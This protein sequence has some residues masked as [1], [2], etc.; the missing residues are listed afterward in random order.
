MNSTPGDMRDAPAPSH[1][2]CLLPS[3]AHTPSVTE[4]TPA[5][6]ITF[7]KRG[8][9]RFAGVRLA[10]HQR[11]F[12]TF[13]A[14][15]DELSQRVPLSFGVRS[16]TTPRGLHGLSALEQLQDGGCYLCSDKKP[17]KTPREPGQ[18]QRKS[19]SAGQSRGFEGGHEAPEI[20][21]SWKGPVAPRRLTLV[22]NGNPRCQQTV[23]VSHR[24]T[25]NLKAFLSKASELL[26][27]PVKQVY[28]PSGKKVDS[29]QTLLDGP[30]L[31]VCAGNEAFRHLEMENDGRHRTRTLSGVTARSGRGCWGP[32]AKQSVMHSRARSGSRLQQ[33]S[34]MSERSGPS[35]HP[36]SG[37]QTWA[38]PTLDKHPRDTPGPPGS[39]VAADDVEKKVCMNEDGSL[40]VEMKVRFQILGEDTLRWPQRVGYASVFAPASGEGQVPREADPFCCKQEGH[41][42][43]FLTHGA[44]GLEP[45]DGRYQGAFDMDQQSQ[46][47][48]DIWR[49]PL[50]TSGGAGPTRRRRWGL[51]KLSGC[52]SHWNQTANDKKGHSNNSP[53]SGPRHPRSAQPGSSCP[54]TSE[55]ETDSDTLH[56]ASSTSSLSGAELGAG[57]DRSLEDTASC[58]LGSETQ[59]I[60]K[61]LSDTSASAESHEMSR[62][63]REQHHRGS[64]QARVTVSQGQATQGDRPC[65]STQSPS[66]LSHMHLQTEKYTQGTTYQEVRGEPELRLPLVPG[67]SASQDTQRHTLP[68]PGG[69]PAQQRQKKQ[70]RPAGIVCLSGA[71]VPYQGAQKGHTRQCHC[72]RD[73]QSSLDTVL[74]RQMPEEGE[75]A[76]PGGL[77]PRFS[78][79]SPSAENEV[80]GDLKSPLSSSLD[81][82]DPQATS[83]A[84]ILPTSDSDCASSFCHPNTRSAEPAGDTECPAHSPASIPVHSGEVGY[85]WDKAGTNP[86]PFSAS[87]LLD[88]WPEAEDPRTHQD[89]CG[90]QVAASPVLTGP[91][92]QT[93]APISEAYWG[94]PNFCPTP[95]QEQTCSRKD[96]T[97]SNSPSSDHGQTDGQ[98]EPRK[99]LLGKSPGNKGSLE[100]QEGDGSVTPSAL[101]Y[102][103]PDAV[104]REWLGNIPEKPALMTC[105]MEGEAT[106]VASDGPESAEE[107]LGD[108]CSQKVLRELA[109]ARKQPPEGATDEQPETT[110]DLPGT[111]SVCCKPGGD[112]CQDAASGRGVEAAT[113]AGIEEGTAVD[114][115]VSLCAL[116]SRVSAS[117][118]IMKALLG[119]KP[120]RPSSLPEISS[121]AAQRLSYSAGTLIACLARLHFFDEDLGPPDGNARFEESPK[122]KEILSISKALW[123]ASVLRQGQLDMDSGLRK[124]TSHQALLGTEDFTPTSSS[125]VDVSS[126]SGGSGEGSVPCATAPDRA[127]LPLKIPS[128]RP[129]SRKQGYPEVPSHSTASPDPQLGACATSGE[130]SSKSG[131]EQ[132]WDKAPEQSMESTMLEEEAQ[133]QETEG[134]VRERLQ[135]DGVHGKEVPQER[136]GVCS[137]GMLQAGSRDGERSPEDTRASKDEEGRD[138]ISG[139]LWPLDGREKPTETPHSF[140]ESNS[141]VSES[142]RVRVLEMRLEEMS[143]VAAM[144][145]KQAYVKAS[146]GTRKTNTPTAHRESLDPDPIW[147]SKLLKKIEKDFMAHLAGATAELRA[148]WNLPDDSLLDQ[149]VTE[150]EQD[151]GRRI[152]AS[153]VREVRKIQSRVGRMVPEPPRE[154]LRGQTSLQ[155]ELRR[156]R[157]QGL[158]NF[159]AFPGQGALSLSLED[160]PILSTA[161]GT[162]P[163]VGIMRD[164][165]CPCEVCLKK[166]MSPQFPKDATAAFSAPVRKAFDLQ[167]ILQNKKGGRNGEAMEL[168]PQKTGMAVPQEDPRSVQGTGGKQEL[169]L[170][171]GLGIDEGE[172]GEGRPRMR[173]EKDPEFFNVEGAGCHGAGEDAATVT[174]RELHVSVARE[175]QQLEEGGT[176]KGEAPYQSFRDREASEASGRQSDGGHSV[177]TQDT[178]RERQPEV[179]GGSQ[180]EKENGTWVSPGEGQRR[181]VSENNSLDQEGGLHKCHRKPGPQ[182]HRAA[183][184]SRASSSGSCSHVSQ[185]SSEEDLS[186]GEL[187]CTKDKHSRVSQAERKVTTMCSESSSEQEVP[188]SPRPPK[189]GEGEEVCHVEDEGTALVCSQL[190]GRSDGFGQ[191]DLDF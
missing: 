82:Q 7:L 43:G 30:S 177:D 126:G 133:S 5:K 6:K 59:G 151:V 116:P 36:T 143:G 176:K 157:L 163:G 185:K 162:S 137:W 160:G 178:S 134:R 2:Q 92:G 72:C 3:V 47:N 120:G 74:Q 11:T 154:A 123:P 168:A 127:D 68:A 94:T 107:D 58:G 132:T 45:C 10:V 52:R 87:V 165:F 164:E 115:G 63:C 180:D 40:S 25:R 172:E 104:V 61:A 35:G 29:L 95:P 186:R 49:N 159:S 142:Q 150:L 167:Q 13:S 88:K 70:K 51:S 131:R 125:G 20:A 41:P 89:C 42:W 181:V 38:A 44:Q 64:G 23:V 84:T 76:Y 136:A 97:S 27:F 71:S 75:Q 15:M 190:G 148:R 86:E 62:E 102:T 28:T 149:M 91:S 77:A 174:E 18:L 175:S 161:L 158:R 83:I 69:A 78:P 21:S 145:C 48:Y 191:D 106:K 129:D 81:F 169:Q 56:P 14:L 66:S 1:R 85:L 152:Q 50:T 111:G 139:A 54:W 179:E 171:A 101:P 140:S 182:C 32:N 183:L 67:H 31:L 22:K 153:T 170:T 128:P 117:T 4:V 189:Q 105:D 24:N 135:E 166:K 46:P 130:E 39:L 12:K 141:N 16:V 144:D 114:H 109:Q 57:K 138:A 100:E 121:T 184:C 187:K 79:H 188:S 17:L 60:E 124:L 26:R 156:R 108:G 98:A 99:T 96:P 53:V 90:L 73:T 173:E 8:D 147:V 93:Q 80:S 55:G 119:S 118:Q 155:T 113:E 65:V 112:A 33:F 9:S 103:S 146:S 122:Y 110:G 37:H 34:L 19:P